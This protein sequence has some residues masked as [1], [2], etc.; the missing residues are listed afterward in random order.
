M[1]R[2]V[3]LPGALAIHLLVAVGHG[4]TH[5]LVPVSLPAWGNGLVVLTVFLGPV[6]GAA[7]TVRG[8]PLGL[9]VFTVSMLG[10]LVLGGMLH[11]LVENP[12]HVALVPADPWRAAFR[13][14]AAAVAFSPALGAAVGGW[15]WLGGD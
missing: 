4:A 6:V 7:L 10:A 3:A 8:H 11:F 12:D 13:A 15:Y 2:R 5:G 9:P 1:D 14:S